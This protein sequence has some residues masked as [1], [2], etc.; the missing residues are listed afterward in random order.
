MTS[1]EET[2]YAIHAAAREGRTAAVESL[3]NA[4]P[5]LATQKDDDERLPIHWAVSYG[6]LDI[7]KLL[8]DR[9]D[10]DPD[11]K[12]RFRVRTT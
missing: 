5:R 11:V 3:L 1:I 2:K 4:N 12:V 7:V 8:V 9:K 10:F 6:H